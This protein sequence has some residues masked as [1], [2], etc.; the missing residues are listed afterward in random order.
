M[1]NCSRITSPS[2]A[3]IP[4]RKFADQTRR[5]STPYF[6][7]NPLQVFNLGVVSFVPGA[8]F[9]TFVADA[10]G[11]PFG[12]VSTN[13]RLRTLGN[14]RHRLRALKPITLGV[15]AS[16][17]RARSTHAGALRYE[18]YQY[19]ANM[20]RISSRSRV[21][22]NASI[23]RIRHFCGLRLSPATMPSASYSLRAM[24]RPL[25]VRVARTMTGC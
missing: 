6:G 17:A 4:S 12:N 11:I 3:S 25:P 16:G 7:G 15:E 19:S 2:A 9:D 18:R 21:L 1:R 10:V 22:V 13:L 23:R 8:D 20:R 14:R 5:E 24:T